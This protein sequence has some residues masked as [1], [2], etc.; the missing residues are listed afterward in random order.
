VRRGAA[1]IGIVLVAALFAACGSSGGSASGGGQ[2]AVTA[3]RPTAAEATQCATQPS[4]WMGC[5][6]RA[7]SAFGNT[8]LSQVSMPGSLGAATANL[9]AQS[10]DVTKGSQC[11]DFTQAMV[12]Q[13]ALVERWNRAQATTL[14]TQLDAGSR[15]LELDVGFNGVDQPTL[16][17]RVDDTLFSEEP[18]QDYLI[19]IATWARAHP[20]E[21]VVVDFR[22]ICQNSAPAAIER[23]LW[24][25]V[26]SSVSLANHGAGAPSLESV[27][28]DASARGGPGL[29]S[30]TIHD[31][32]HADGGGHN[33]VLLVPSDAPARSYMARTLQAQPYLVGSRAATVSFTDTGVAPTSVSGYGAANQAIE[34]GARTAATPIGSLAGKGLYVSPIAYDLG[35]SSLTSAATSALYSTFGGLVTPAPPLPP[36]ESGLW[37]GAG[38]AAPSAAAIASSWGHKANVVAVDGIDLAGVVPAVIDL[39]GS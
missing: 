14:A 7:R 26:A 1:A 31:V 8:P 20:T 27:L 5:L 37:P 28:Y 19:D 21:V 16:A 23:A 24:D 22:M 12:P 29:G 36:W 32:V 33:V 15:F 38:G 9:D 10:F 2:G 34:H 30:L 13:G 6:V 11:S 17:W 3:A 39:N 35:A 25:D 4:N 18:L